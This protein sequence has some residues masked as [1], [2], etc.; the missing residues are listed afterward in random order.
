MFQTIRIPVTT[1]ASGAATVLDAHQING[2]ID[3]IL[4]VDGTFDDGVDVTITLETPYYSLPVFT[5]ANF[6]TAQVAYPRAPT[7]AVADGTQLSSTTMVGG[8]GFLKVVVAQGGNTKS[9][10]FI[11]NIVS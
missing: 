7:H 9:G 8:V 10:S 11:F 2:Y 6:N 3:S 4:L 1:D 5:K